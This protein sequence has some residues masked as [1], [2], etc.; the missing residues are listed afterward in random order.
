MEKKR[1]EIGKLEERIA[2]CAA[3][4]ALVAGVAHDSVDLELGPGFGVPSDDSGASQVGIF[5]SGYATTNDGGVSTAIH[6]HFGPS[7][8][9]CN[10]PPQPS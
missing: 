6:A 3:F 10:P 7:P 8:S 1:F 2:P 9:T 4:G 5:K